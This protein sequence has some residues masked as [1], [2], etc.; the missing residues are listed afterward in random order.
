MIDG[1][2]IIS[3]DRERQGPN[4]TSELVG[5]AFLKAI[6]AGATMI[7]ICCDVID[8]VG[9]A[10]MEGFDWPISASSTD[11]ASFAGG[12]IP[13]RGLCEAQLTCTFPDNSRDSYIPSA[14]K[15][16]N[17]SSSECQPA[18]NGNV[19]IF[20]ANN[21]NQFQ[22]S[23]DSNPAETLIVPCYANSNP[24]VKRTPT[25]K[26]SISREQSYDGF[27][28]IGD[29]SSVLSGSPDDDFVILQN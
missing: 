19:S 22:I 16:S 17:P 7:K 10:I 1:Y 3:G 14:I 4:V 2:S 27:V 8:E 28:I 21:S 12:N 9:D 20:Q 15:L 11:H 29:P 24:F 26:E 13:D 23:A 18:I 25:A 6:N 5:H